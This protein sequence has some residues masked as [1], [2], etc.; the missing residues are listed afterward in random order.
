MAP[1]V[2]RIEDD[3]AKSEDLGDTVRFSRPTPFG[4]KVWTRKKTELDTYEKSIWD[5]DQQKK[6]STDSSKD[7][8]KHESTAS[9][10][11]DTS[12]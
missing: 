8:P 5:R 3:P 9:Q 4:P 1:Q 12:K 10:K 7:A 2:Q 6:S 11:T